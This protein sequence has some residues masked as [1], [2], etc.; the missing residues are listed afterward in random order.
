[1][2]LFKRDEQDNNC[3]HDECKNYYTINKQI[4]MYNN[5]Q[6]SQGNLFAKG[7]R[8]NN[9]QNLQDSEFL[10][11]VRKKVK[12]ETPG[13]SFWY[14]YS[15]TGLLTI[16]SE[17]RTPETQNTPIDNLKNSDKSITSQTLGFQTY[18]DQKKEFM[19]NLLLNSF[20]NPST[21]N[22]KTE[23]PTGNPIHIPYIQNA[24]QIQQNTQNS[25]LLAN[26]NLS[27]LALAQL[28][29]QNM[30]IKPTILN[31]PGSGN[32]NPIFQSPSDS[33]SSF[34]MANKVK[35]LESFSP[36]QSYEPPMREFQNRIFGLLITQNKMLVDLKEK[37]EI[38]H[39]ALGC[40]INEINSL[41]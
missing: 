23:S 28:I 25:N 21:P 17:I 24:N 37:N 40:L 30:K 35:P 16:D 31:T 1:M 5:I 4:C 34:N 14:V 11:L 7:K 29:T 10:N 22:P 12:V 13:K 20:L 41:K 18:G 39:D 36:N 6:Q 38:F 15:F 32:T 2:C 9:M 19:S 8:T 27:Q 33:N 26:S 3:N